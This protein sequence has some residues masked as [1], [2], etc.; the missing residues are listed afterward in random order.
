MDKVTKEQN[1]A[2][3][4]IDAFLC[5]KYHSMGKCIFTQDPVASNA[6]K[7]MVSDLS[8]VIGST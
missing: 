7:V 4:H 5:S 3:H 8:H 2:K 6:V 1:R